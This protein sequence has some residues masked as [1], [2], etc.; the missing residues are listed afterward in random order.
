MEPNVKHHH[1]ARHFR[2]ILREGECRENHGCGVA[3]ICICA[4]AEDVI[5]AL[6][7]AE[8][9]ADR[10][11]KALY[12]FAAN[13][14][15]FDDAEDCVIYQRTSPRHGNLPAI[16]VGDLRRAYAALASREE[17]DGA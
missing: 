5:D 1:S 9:K 16:T 10:L 8:E 4:F 15:R 2:K 14:A 7:A 13:G 12:P 6:E 17:P 3:E 11:E